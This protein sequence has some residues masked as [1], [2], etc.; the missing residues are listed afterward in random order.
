MQ[1]AV[2]SSAMIADLLAGL[3]QLDTSS[4]LELVPDLDRILRDK[5]IPVEH[6]TS[7]KLVRL[8]SVPLGAT[9]VYRT[10]DILGHEYANGRKP[11]FE[12]KVVRV[13]DFKPR[14][15]NQIVLEDADGYQCL[16]PL[17]EVEK[18]LSLKAVRASIE[19]SGSA[20]STPAAS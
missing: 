12:G 18:A 8:G 9:F 4:L 14:Y 20:S 11:S 1:L 10:L 7:G 6:R 15:V 5:G 2:C 19:Q 17:H 13:V 3:E 16:L